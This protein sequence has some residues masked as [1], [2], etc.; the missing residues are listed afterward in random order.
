M[1]RVLR[2][3]ESLDPALR[4]LFHRNHVRLLLHRPVLSLV[5]L[6]SR[7]DLRHVAKVNYIHVIQV[8]IATPL[9]VLRLQLLGAPGVL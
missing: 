1:C 7:L 6:L 9:V 4:R 5:I 2:H 3:S 8:S